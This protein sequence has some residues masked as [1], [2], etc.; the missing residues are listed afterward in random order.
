MNKHKFK[1]V[2]RVTKTVARRLFNE[3]VKLLF[4]PVKWNPECKEEYSL[5]FE[6]EKMNE[7]DLIHDFDTQVNAF[8]YY[9]CNYETGYYTAFYKFL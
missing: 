6:I 9:N 2:E 3:G 5:S 8:E 7:P 1:S 4:C